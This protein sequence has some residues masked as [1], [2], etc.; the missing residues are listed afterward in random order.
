MSKQWR[1]AAWSIAG[2]LMLVPLAAMRLTDEVRW[3][4]ADFAVFAAMLAAAIG[5][6]ELFARTGSG[7]AYRAGTAFAIGGAV[8]LFWVNG[9]VGI[10]GSEDDPANLM[11]AGVLATGVAGATLARL[12]AAGMARAM[13]ATAVAQIAVGAIALGGGMGAGD[14]SW[15]GDVIGAT[16]VFAALWLAA[17]WL[18][19][20]AARPGTGAAG[21]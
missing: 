21:A 20:H 17:A 3:T 16:G 15:P 7:A 14:R 5:G 12:R 9:A 2:A 6:F 11:F 1:I 4:V 8:L 10:I 18:F 13:A 19:A